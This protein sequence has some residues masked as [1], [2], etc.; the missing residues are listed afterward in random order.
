MVAAKDGECFKY[1][2]YQSSGSQLGSRVPPKG[3][4]INLRCREMINGK[5]KKKDSFFSNSSF[6]CKTVDNLTFLGNIEKQ[7]ISTLEK[8]ELENVSHYC[9]NDLIFTNSQNSGHW[10]D[11]Y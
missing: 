1:F 2:I 6:I 8:L 7:Q 11:L 9:F 10:Y 5:G 3:P 4:E